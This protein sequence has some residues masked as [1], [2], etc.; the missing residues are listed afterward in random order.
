MSRLLN[1]LEQNCELLLENESNSK[2]FEY[3]NTK[4]RVSDHIAPVSL[5]TMV[6][7][8]QVL[9]P[10]NSRK[11]YILILNGEIHIYESFT[12][13]KIF[14]ENM[15]LF[16]NSISTKTKLKEKKSVKDLTKRLIHANEELDII[17]SK[18]FSLETFSKG[19]QK[20]IKIWINEKKKS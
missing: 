6:S 19:Q 9:L 3:G 13:L 15:F 16:I 20:Q 18:S 4:I 12:K 10:K 11:H 7:N 14:F 2:Y 8:I 17:K 5:Q 1:F